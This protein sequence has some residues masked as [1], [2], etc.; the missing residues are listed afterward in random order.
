VR[1]LFF[2]RDAF[3]PFRPDVNVLFAKEMIRRGHVID[4][5]LQSEAPCNEAYFTTWKSCN[6]WVGATDKGASWV[7]RLRKH[8]LGFV[9]DM[10]GVALLRKRN[11]DFIQ[12]RDKF[13]FPVLGILASKM[14]RCKFLYWLSFPFPEAFLYEAKERIARYPILYLLRGL[15]SKFLLNNI[16]M[17]YADH[18]FVQSDRMKEDCVSVRIAA[19]KLTAVPMGVALEEFPESSTGKY[20]ALERNEKRVVYLGALDKIRRLDFLIKVFK[21]VLEVVPGAKLYLVGSSQNPNDEDWLRDEAEQQ[22]IMDSVFFTGFLPQQIALK[23]V[24]KADVCVSPIYPSSIYNASSPTKLIEYMAKA[25]AVVAND[26]PDQRI[27]LEKSGGGICVPYEE[28][29]FAAAIVELLSDPT[30]AEHMGKRGRTYVKNE[31]SYYK[32]ANLLEEKYLSICNRNS[33]KSFPFPVKPESD[34]IA[35]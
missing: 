21:K 5:V 12:V 28:D 24:S 9:H 13:F 26:N 33:S 15:I 34:Q 35:H 18:I 20:F 7:N 8:V 4:W 3:P 19:E 14:F 22:G 11:Y 6:V 2:A 29:A 16:I 32:I 10:R 1:F 27:V 23:H 25:K 30:K 31:R 17:R